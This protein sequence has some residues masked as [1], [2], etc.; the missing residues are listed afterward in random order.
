MS[1]HFRQPFE[2]FIVILC[3]IVISLIS[4]YVFYRIIEKPAQ[5]WSRKIV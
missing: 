3:G 4:A 2:K 5:N 1:H